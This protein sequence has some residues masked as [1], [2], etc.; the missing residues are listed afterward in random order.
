[1]TLHIQLGIS[2]IICTRNRA[3][4]LS[5]TLEALEK[6]DVPENSSC[7]L[8]VI[9]NGS[10][11]N[12]RDVVERA[13]LSRMRLRYV[14]EPRRGLSNARNRG[15]AES[16]GTMIVFTDDD[17]R[18]ETRWLLALCAPLIENTADAVLGCVRMAPHLERDWLTGFLRIYVACN[19][20][21]LTRNAANL[22]IGANMGFHRRVLE[23]VS[24]FD[25]ELGA[26]T[27]RGFGEDTLFSCQLKEAGFRT[28]H[29]FDA[30]VEHHFAEDRLEPGKFLA[31]MKGIGRSAGYTAYHWE[32]RRVPRARLQWLILGAKLILRRL[33]APSRWSAGTPGWEA[34]YLRDQAFLG[35]FLRS[36]GRSRKYAKM[37][38]RKHGRLSPAQ[39]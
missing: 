31:A 6:C 10:T 19:D 34:V 38:L 32:H 8:I 18:P 27:A 37:G 33:F 36:N 2:V 14:S 28:T 1:M 16:T 23:K 17:I 22:L 35:E 21:Q 20:R 11:D 30:C 24:G 26:G 4:S 15:I 13:T 5:T 25:D 9:D 39:G 12:T 3:D 7:E 29:V